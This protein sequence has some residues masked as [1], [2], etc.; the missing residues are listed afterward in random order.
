MFLVSDLYD[1]TELT[2]TTEGIKGNKIMGG[3]G[4]RRGEWKWIEKKA[5]EKAKPQEYV[6][7]E[8]SRSLDMISRKP[9]MHVAQTARVDGT[10]PG[11]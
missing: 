1:E 6:I 8:N 9:H 3:I 2:F 4:Y 10:P 11:T 7:K 5:A